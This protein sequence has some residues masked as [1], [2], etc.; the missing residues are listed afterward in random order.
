MTAPGGVPSPAARFAS[1]TPLLA[2]AVVA[3]LGASNDPTRIGG[4]PIAYMQAQGFAGT[5]LP[6][7]PNRDTVQG[8]RAYPSV[9]ALLVVPDVAIVAVP[10]AA[11][12]QAVDDL[13]ARGVKGAIV[14]TAGF[15]EMD[16]SGEALQARLVATAS[17]HG[18]RL[19]GPNC[20]GLF[21][22]RL[23][24]YPIFSSSFENG[25]PKPGRI[26]IASQSGAYGTHMFAAARDRNI[27]TP[28]CVTTGNEGDVTIGDVIGWLVEDPETDVIAAYAEGIRESDSLL[29]ALAAART[30]RKPVVVMKVGRSVLGSQ[31]AKSHTASICGNDAVTDAVLAEFGAVRARTTEEMLDIAYTATRRVYPAR[32]SLGVITISGGA[33]VLI[34]DAAEAL[35]L[36]MPPMPAAT[37]ARLKAALP[38]AAPAN[39]VDCTAQAFNDLSLIGSFTEAMVAEGG[40]ASVLAFFT[41]V[42]ASPTL[43]PGL[44]AQV[45]AVKARHPDRLYVMS[46]LAPPERVREYEADG[47]AVFEDPTRATVAIHAMG[48]F[49]AAFAAAP[50]VP[51]P[52]L[53]TFTLPDTT[54]DEAAAKRLLAGL[55]IAIAPEHACA[56]AE[57][58]VEA[59]RALGF[60]VVMK[61]LS[62]DILHKSEIGGVIL[63]VADEAAVRAG[64]ATLAARGAAVPGARIAGVLVARQMRGGV[65]CILGI[66]RDPVFG[67]IA[68]FGLGGIFVEVLHDVAMHRCPFGSEVA[69][70][71]IRSIRGAPLLLGA[72]GRPPADIPALA[73]MLS[74]L[75]VF[76]VQ[77][78]P[79]LRSVDLNPVFALPAGQGATAADAVV[80]IGEPA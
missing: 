79:R 68:M 56:T 61:I 18:M 14:F 15:A 37:Q 43:A 13:G 36:P 23:G 66:H 80:E 4:R 59:A 41:Q 29:A 74:R 62:P 76:A 3:V 19:L 7:N 35:G 28:I 38:F 57:A 11:V 6:V 27:G 69:E 45:N 53:P 67:P 10:A 25:W 8:L 32:N 72:R 20:L 65:E 16:A 77:A 31:A 46:V 34:S 2:P 54:P 5:I 17:A 26:G 64:F 75:S 30:A 1:L 48:R 58:A 55:G 63:G 24:Y 71:M 33:G 70:A 50:A 78:G 40:Y 47:Y 42:G 39:P 73:A 21:N 9:A 60:P 22:A 49:G 12:V 51:P 52:A 44:R